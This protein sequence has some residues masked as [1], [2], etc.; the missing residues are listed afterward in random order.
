M[1][2]DAATAQAMADIVAVHAE[3]AT[4][5]RTYAELSRY[6]AVDGGDTN[7]EAEA[8]VGANA[9]AG[10]VIPELARRLH[11]DPVATSQA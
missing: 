9:L 7:D 8:V 1:V 10:L 4:D 2:C 3:E 5:G 6:L 11:V